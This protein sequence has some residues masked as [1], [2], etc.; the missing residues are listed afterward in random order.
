VIKNTIVDAFRGGALLEKRFEMKRTA[1]N[2]SKEAKIPIRFGVNNSAIV[3]FGASGA[4][5]RRSNFA[6]NTGTAPLKAAS[7][8]AKAVINHF[9]PCLTDRSTVDVDRQSGRVESV[10]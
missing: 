4:N 8:G 10:K 9:V 3:R 6:E 5:I 1:R 2:T 7:V